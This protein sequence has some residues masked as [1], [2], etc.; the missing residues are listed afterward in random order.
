MQES[1]QTVSLGQLNAVFGTLKMHANSR[2]ETSACQYS[3]RGNPRGA[4]NQVSTGVSSAS[5]T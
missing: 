2:V 1:G 5:Q 4:L 3:N